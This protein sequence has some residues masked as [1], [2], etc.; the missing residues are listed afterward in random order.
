MDQHDVDY[1]KR[2]SKFSS[3]V[4]FTDG[5]SLTEALDR[6]IQE[7]KVLLGLLNKRVIKQRSEATSANPKMPKKRK[8]HNTDQNAENDRQKIGF[9]RQS[10]GHGVEKNQ[11][12]DDISEKLML[13]ISHAF[14]I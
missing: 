6:L 7:N 13:E 10:S 1:I 8:R 12:N 2:N 3:L 11:P 5:T 9:F 4:N 14:G